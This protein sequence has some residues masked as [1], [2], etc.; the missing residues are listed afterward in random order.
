MTDHHSYTF[1]ALSA[2]ALLLSTLF[3]VSTTT[4]AQYLNIQIKLEP[5]FKTEI[6][7][8]LNFGQIVIGSG[9]Q[10]IKLGDPRMGVFSITAINAQTVWLSIDNTNILKHS[11]PSVTDSIPFNIQAAYNNDGINEYK[12]A[13]LFDGGHIYTQ[14]SDKVSRNSFSWEILYIYIFGSINVGDIQDGVYSGNI[15]LTVNFD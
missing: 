9:N 1:F 10:T 12:N 15:Y 14:I 4:N 8:P 5:E 13:K 6:L 7:K 11:N 2:L 3:L